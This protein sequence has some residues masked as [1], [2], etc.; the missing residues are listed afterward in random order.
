MNSGMDALLNYTVFHIGVY[1]TLGAAIIAADV[2]W[3]RRS[4]LLPISIL[5]LLIAGASGGIV[6]G[7]IPA[8]SGTDYSVFLTRNAR[9]LFDFDLGIKYWLVIAI[10]HSAFWI[11]II[12]IIAKFAFWRW[13]QN[14]DAKSPEI[15][16]KVVATSMAKFLEKFSGRVDQNEAKTESQIEDI[17]E[18][19]QNL[20]KQIEALTPKNAG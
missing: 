1:I 4:K 19:L 15:E 10:E 18:T 16:N 17:N 11:A 12:L 2:F 7:N 14:K 9:I 20:S 13:K 3:N 5:F 8:N 6:A